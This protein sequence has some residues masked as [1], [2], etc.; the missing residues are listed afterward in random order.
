MSFHDIDEGYPDG[1]KPLHFYYNREERIKHAPKIV[2]D[3]YEGKGT[4]PPRGLFRALVATRANRLMLMAVV[5]CTILVLFMTVL[6]GRPD[7][8]QIGPAAVGLSAFSFEDSIYV[9]LHFESATA[10]QISVNDPVSVT[11][12]AV[13]ADGQIS[14]QQV[15]QGI[16]TGREYFLRTKFSDY[17]IIKVLAVVKIAGK[18]ETLTASVQRR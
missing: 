14:A 13:D 5:A 16:F 8:K 12:D 2:K 4:H 3:Y 7:R 9:S 11:V 1:E 6:S 17:D 18:T 10:Q 15:L